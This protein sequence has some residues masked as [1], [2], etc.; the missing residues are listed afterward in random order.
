[1]VDSVYQT[2]I[3]A[4]GAAAKNSRP[5]GMGDEAKAIALDGGPAAQAHQAG[6][7]SFPDLLEQSINTSIDTTY[8]GEEVSLKSLVGKADLHEMVTAVTHAELTLQTVVS[9]RDR[10]IN[11]YQDILKMPI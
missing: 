5:A 1:M 8:K 6:K 9:V 2:A 10:V 4:Y 7:P 3:K 11:A